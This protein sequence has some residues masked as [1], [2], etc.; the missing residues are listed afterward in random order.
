MKHS[1]CMFRHIYVTVISGQ[2]YV[3]GDE[4]VIHLHRLNYDIDQGSDVACDSDNSDVYPEES[5]L[6]RD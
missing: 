2:C 5:V 3:C 1:I 4:E 6:Y